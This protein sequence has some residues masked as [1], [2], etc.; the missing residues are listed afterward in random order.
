VIPTARPLCRCG[1]MPVWSAHAAGNPNAGDRSAEHAV[2][3]D[4]CAR[5]IV[6]FLKVVGGACGS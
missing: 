5:E 6:R 4:R 2:P 1:T 3:A